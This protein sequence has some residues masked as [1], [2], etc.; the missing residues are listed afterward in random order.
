[1]ENKNI[2]KAVTWILKNEREEFER[3]LAKKHCNFFNPH[4]NHVPM[5]PIRLVCW[6]YGPLQ[7]PDA[8]WHQTLNDTFVFN[9]LK[10]TKC[11][12]FLV[13]CFGISE[14]LLLHNYTESFLRKNIQPT[15]Y[16]HS[17]DTATLFKKQTNSFKHLQSCRSV[18]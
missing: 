16:N 11:N 17:F 10:L 9:Y 3:K 14:N 13:Y 6:I 1:M 12:W 18:H 5:Y 8:I 7:S 15:I 2:F 4:K